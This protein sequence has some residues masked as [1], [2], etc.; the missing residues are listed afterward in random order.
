MV[1]TNGRRIAVFDVGLP[2]GVAF[3]RSL[4][5]A[6]V[7]VT[8]YASSGLAPGRFSRY[9]RRFRRA[10]PVDM[11]D[12]FVDW[13]TAEMGAGRIDLVAPTSDFVVYAAAEAY[14]R[15]G[16][17]APTGLAPRAALHDCLYKDRFADVMARA[18][19]P[20]PP[21]AAPTTL[22]EAIGAA[23][24]FGYPVVLKPRT[25][26]GLVRTRGQVIRSI[27]ELRL[28]FEPYAL[29]G[30]SRGAPREDPAVALPL[31]Q[32][33]LGR[34][35]ND[36][37]SVSGCLAPDGATL[38]VAHSRKL[39][40]WP[41]PLGV[42]TMF[43]ALPDQPYTERA[44]RA[45]RVALGAGLFELELLVCR[46]S[47]EV[48]PI[49]LN[50]RAYGQVSLAMAHGWDLP[51]LWYSSVCDADLRPAT[52][53]VRRPRYWRYGLPYY[54]RVGFDL[55]RGPHRRAAAQALVESIRQHHA[56]AMF[57]WRDPLPAL[58]FGFGGLRHPGGLL[59]PL[60]AEQREGTGGPRVTH[61]ARAVIG[62]SVAAGLGELVAQA[63]SPR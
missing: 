35:G 26:V 58:V 23:E 31:L 19:L 17:S 36:V 27:D 1:M 9:G 45:V 8:A 37:V 49:D 6:G 53:P 57:D 15:V 59:R 33:Y 16:V 41:G 10:P 5:A 51:R 21:T 56:G 14:E 52:A 25:H 47:G 7:D 61:A 46:S 24:A 34:A 42:G 30:R 22:D 12:Q 39:Q 63:G 62:M 48:W 54:S 32:A 18:G 2:P 28:A 60:L 13:L 50:P 40:Q 4:G 38:A 55:L 20:T 43:E 3:L 11:I 29:H 44:L